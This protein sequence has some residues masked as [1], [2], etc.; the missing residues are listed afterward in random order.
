MTTTSEQSVGRALEAAVGRIALPPESS[1]IPE[2]RPRSGGLT[3]FA[4]VAAVILV[5][6]VGAELS[7]LRQQ[8]STVGARPNAFRVADDAE[9][10]WIRAALPADVVVLRP[11]WIPAEFMDVGTSD[12]PTPLGI[13][14]VSDRGYVF[15]YR[16]GKLLNP[17]NA[18]SCPKI[19]IKRNAYQVSIQLIESGVVNERGTTVLVRTGP[20]VLRNGTPYQLIYLNWIEDGTQFELSSLDL[21]MMEIL[22]VLRSLEPMK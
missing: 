12:C 2:A 19:E 7:T 21:E 5:L 4:A 13:P 16:K 20:V 11:T 9:W 18:N 10:A 15:N 6:L 22:R 3:A 1:W 14:I 17:E 8:G